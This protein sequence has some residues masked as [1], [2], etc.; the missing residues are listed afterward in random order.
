MF[1]IIKLQLCIKT[2]S[3]VKLVCNLLDCESATKGVPVCLGVSSSAL[4]LLFT[5][6][7]TA[8]RV[9]SGERFRIGLVINFFFT[10]KRCSKPHTQI[11]FLFPLFSPEKRINKGLPTSWFDRTLTTS[12][13][14]DY[15]C[16][17]RYDSPT[18]FQTASYGVG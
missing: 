15:A 14:T 8:I 4:W 5:T 1:L 12:H 17:S 6:N 2:V 11:L 16:V 18:Q 10:S 7:K 9:K 3:P 13:I